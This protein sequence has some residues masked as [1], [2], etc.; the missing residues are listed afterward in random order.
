VQHYDP[1]NSLEFGTS[2]ICAASAVFAGSL[3]AVGEVGID[4]FSLG[5]PLLLLSF[6]VG[7]YVFYRWWRPEPAISDICGTLAVITLSAATA[8]IISLAGLRFGAPLIDGK[9]AAFDSAFLLD[10][11]S[12]VVAVANA[13]VFAG[14]MG[15]A[16]DSSFPILIA[17]VVLLAWTRH[18]RPLWQLAFVF[19]FTAFGCATLSVFFPAAGAFFHF[20]YPAEVFE[21]LPSG[22]G[23]YHLSR[24]S[25]SV[26]LHR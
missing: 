6:L 11:R 14:L 19:A 18:V 9:L 25:L 17:S 1:K 3:V 21:G 23:V 10:T 4:V 12:I 15:L 7:A 22:A 5:T 20:A 16:Y 26:A 2:L 13:R 8:G 24:R